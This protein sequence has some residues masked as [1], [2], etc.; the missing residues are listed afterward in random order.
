LLPLRRDTCS[1]TQTA[2]RE[3]HCHR[4][5]ALSRIFFVGI[6]LDFTRASEPVAVD[7]PAS[8]CPLAPSVVYVLPTFGWERQTA[9]NLKR[10]LIE[11]FE[12][13]SANFTL[14][15][16]HTVEPLGRLIYAETFDLDNALIS[17]T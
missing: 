7:V 10:L 4:D 15:S 6:N 14:G 3:L 1:T 12:N 17:E 9:T 16:G 5:V 8:A 13:I 2:P 11:E